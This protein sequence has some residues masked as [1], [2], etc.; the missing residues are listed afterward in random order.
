MPVPPDYV[1]QLSVAVAWAA[2]Y[3]GWTYDA[4][5]YFQQG[6][7]KWWRWGVAD[8]P[9]DRVAFTE[10]IVHMLGVLIA[11]VSAGGWPIALMYLAVVRHWV[12]PLTGYACLLLVVPIFSIYWSGR[13]RP[14]SVRS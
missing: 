12:G 3:V 7:Y 4:R 8:A 13:Y 14:L 6:R 9:A 11:M 5:H 2:G 1:R 10:S